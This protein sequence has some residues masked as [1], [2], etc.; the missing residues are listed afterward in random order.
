MKKKDCP[1]EA[2]VTRAAAADVALAAAHAKLSAARDS[3]A[4]AEKS[5]S[6]AGK[7]KN[8]ERTNSA[9]S[10]HSSPTRNLQPC[11]TTRPGEMCIAV[12]ADGEEN[13]CGT[14]KLARLLARMPRATPVAAA[15]DV[16]R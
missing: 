6:A 2:D 10:T 4:A 13:K 15:H 1:T 16:S 12:Y 9:N 11:V 14:R 8:L 7:S 5:K 3:I